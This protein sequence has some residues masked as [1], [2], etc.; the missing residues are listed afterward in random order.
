MEDM[1]DEYQHT[2]L[3]LESFGLTTQA[4][5]VDI[6]AVRFDP[7][8]GET[9]LVFS[10]SVLLQDA[11]DAGLK[12][13]AGT[14]LWWLQ[15]SDEARATLVEGQS[16]AVSLR[17]ALVDLGKFIRSVPRTYVWGNGAKFDLGV[18][19]H[20]YERLGIPLPWA[21]YRELDVRTPV[22]LGRH[23]GIDP[24]GEAAFKGVEHTT[25]DDCFHQI[26]YISKICR[27]LD[28][29]PETLVETFSE[30]K[31]ASE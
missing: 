11:L 13:D 30:V 15:Q 16:R 8:T 9:S 24:K 17:T 23:L 21:H 10:V 29:K 26:N 27:R 19:T 22:F 6:G 4:A 5:F 2:M 31:N 1:Q 25:V 20:A 7:F 3:D 18:L 14:V 12:V 28:L